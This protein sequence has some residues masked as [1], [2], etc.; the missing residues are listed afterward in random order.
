M[1][2]DGTWPSLSCCCGF[3]ETILLGCAVEGKRPFAVSCERSEMVFNTKKMQ[4]ATG[5]IP[6]AGGAGQVMQETEHSV[7]LERL[8]GGMPFQGLRKLPALPGA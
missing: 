5:R 6:F 3:S 7:P 4:R 1:R 2:R 8:A